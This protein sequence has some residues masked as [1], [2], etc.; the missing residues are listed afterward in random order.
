MSQYWVISVPIDK[1]GQE[2][3]EAAR[4]RTWRGLHAAVSDYSHPFQFHIP[5]LRVGTLDSLLAL[6]DDLVRSCTAAEQTTAKLNRQIQDTSRGNGQG[7]APPLLVDGVP[8]ERYLT[9]FQW[10]EAK[11]PH[12][13]PLKETVES[14]NA[15]L[16]MLEEDLKVRV[17]E[18]NSV[19]SSFAA[20]NRKAQGT[21]AVKDLTALVPLDSIVDS[22]NLTTLLAVVP[23][24][25]KKDWEG[26]YHTLTQYVVPKSSRLL[27]EDSDYALY[28]V[29]LFKRVTDAFRTAAVEKGYQI[30]EFT[31]PEPSSASTEQQ[32]Q[33]LNDEHARTRG[34]LL[35]W[36]ATAYSEAFSSWLHLIAVRTF[37]E[38]ILR[39]G[40]PPS[41]LA[42]VIEP[43]GKNEKRLR[44][45]LASRYGRSQT[46]WKEDDDA[47]IAG[48]TT[49]EAHPYVSLSLNLLA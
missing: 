11:H 42:V 49:E 46:H 8:V 40:L 1:V 22:E 27:E 34:S 37:V 6:S 26:T 15:G 7:G 21:L 13:R 48:V 32:A 44:N 12:R 23:R 25:C 39:F 47:A 45:L 10:D 43:V 30:R 24:H 3:A 14:I 5:D 17:G 16:A 29:V 4:A 20:F 9:A 38:S 41:F 36:C 2:D 28:T 19:K 35:E 33:E 31:P 18:Y